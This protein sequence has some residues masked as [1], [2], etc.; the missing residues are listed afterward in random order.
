[1]SERDNALLI[2]DLD[3]FKTINDQYGHDIGDRALCRVASLLQ[4]RFR[5]EDYI[6]R[7]GGDEFAV[8]MVHADS[9]LGNLVKEKIRGINETLKIP[10]DG[11]PPLSLSVG[12]AFGDRGNPTED[13]FKDADTA[14]YR[15]KSVRPGGC[16]IY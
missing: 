12:V 9:S 10:Q 5:A 6:C 8:I 14:L 7:I 15:T 3:K 2:I 13:I 1:L 4:E 16:E 11:L